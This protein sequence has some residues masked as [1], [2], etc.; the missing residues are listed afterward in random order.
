MI[1]VNGQRRD[2]CDN[3]NPYVYMYMCLFFYSSMTIM[4]VCQSV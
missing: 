3:W 2:A 1:G 4:R